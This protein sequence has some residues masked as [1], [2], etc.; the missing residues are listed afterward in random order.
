M[1]DSKLFKLKVRDPKH[2][3][4][5]GVKLSHSEYSGE[6]AGESTCIHAIMAPGDITVHVRSRNGANTISNPV[7]PL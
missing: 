5:A 1:L 2:S 3:V 4:S 7:F 6:H